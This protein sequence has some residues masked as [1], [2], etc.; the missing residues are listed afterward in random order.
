MRSS[1]RRILL[2]SGASLLFTILLYTRLGSE[3]KWQLFQLLSSCRADIPF[4]F[5][6]LFP[7]VSNALMWMIPF[8]DLRWSYYILTFFATFLLLGVYRRYLGLFSSSVR[9]TT[10][11]LLLFPLAW[12]YVVVNPIFIPSDLVGVAFL[13]I[14]LYLIHER[15]WRYFY[16]IYPLAVL[17]RETA[18]Y[19]ALAVLVTAP[20]RMRLRTALGHV[21]VQTVVWAGIKYLLFVSFDHLDGDMYIDTLAPNLDFLLQV[22]T[23]KGSSPLWL[24]IFGLVWLPGV[25]RW[26]SMPLFVR[27]LFLIVPPA[28]AVMLAAGEIWETRIFTELSVILATPTALLMLRQDPGEG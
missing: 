16:W 8:L 2:Y 19:L 1:L 6:I 13:T 7:A 17:N 14:G 9:S 21:L 25:I 27:R 18:I 23:F 12:N 24:T 5:R 28:F 15:N 26:R 3:E 10:P 4:Q 20:G 22:V 11:L